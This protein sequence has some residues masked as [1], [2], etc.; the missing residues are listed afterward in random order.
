MG[1]FL[2]CNEWFRDP[3]SFHPVEWR[4]TNIFCKGPESQCLRLC[5][6][7]VP[8]STLQLCLCICSFIDITLKYVGLAVS[9]ETLF[10]K[11][12][13]LPELTCSLLTL[14]IDLQR[15]PH[16]VNGWA[17]RKAYLLNRMRSEMTHSI[18]LAL[19]V[20]KMEP[21]LDKRR[22]SWEMEALS[23]QVLPS[24]CNKDGS[25]RDWVISSCFYHKL[26]SSLI[27]T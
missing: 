4:S 5:G 17:E 18:C 6:R 23:G 27:F 3:D 1:S 10:T 25:L 21:H 7:R 9:S 8:V 12:G 11:T 24:L 26:Y 16:L 22:A 13:S 15:L 20:A 2:P 14:A 19:L